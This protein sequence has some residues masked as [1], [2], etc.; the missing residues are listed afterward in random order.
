MAYITPGRRNLIL[1]SREKILLNQKTANNLCSFNNSNEYFI[2]NLSYDSLNTNKQLDKYS[3]FIDFCANTIR[4][5]GLSTNKVCEAYPIDGLTPEEEKYFNENV[6]KYVENFQEKLGK[7]KDK[8]GFQYA[9]DDL[10]YQINENIID[11]TMKDKKYNIQSEATIYQIL[12]ERV[13]QLKLCLEKS[14]ASKLEIPS[15]IIKTNEEEEYYHQEG[16]R[17]ENFLKETENHIRNHTLIEPDERFFH[18]LSPD[19]KKRTAIGFMTDRIQWGIK[20]FYA[21]NKEPM[22][23]ILDEL[24]E[25]I[26][27][28]NSII[29]ILMTFLPLDLFNND[30]DKF[31]LDRDKLKK[32]LESKG[33]K[34]RMNIQQYRLGLGEDL[35]T[36]NGIFLS[37]FHQLWSTYSLIFDINN[38]CG[39][40]ADYN[41]YL[42]LFCMYMFGRSNDKV[43]PLSFNLSSNTN[44]GL[45]D[46]ATESYSFRNR[47][48][49]NA[50][51]LFNEES[52]IKF[53]GLQLM[54]YQKNNKVRVLPLFVFI[55]L[56]YEESIKPDRVNPDDNG[57]SEL[58]S[59]YSLE[60]LKIFI[61]NSSFFLVENGE[62][63]PTMNIT[64]HE[65]YN[66]LYY[67]MRPYIMN[68]D[69]KLLYFTMRN[70]DDPELNAL[71]S[72][73]NMEEVF[74]LK[75]RY[76]NIPGPR[77]L[78]VINLRE[79]KTL[80][81]NGFNPLWIR[82]SPQ[83]PDKGFLICN[84]EI[85]NIEAITGG[86]LKIKSKKIQKTLK[87][88][89]NNTKK[90]SK[91]IVKRI[92][93]RSKKNKK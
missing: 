8:Q 37:D 34:E 80:I 49:L 42:N 13:K 92:L 45:F 33:K 88:K 14:K 71:I 20:N 87:N 46:P 11:E 52:S 12:K 40:F 68:D 78:S 9:T 16:E 89:V 1:D 61:C 76:P 84:Q 63:S 72:Q 65:I 90:N 85:P 15:R 55:D 28:D 56:E 2:F 41:I 26:E 27:R 23:Q 43:F 64:H 82:E 60:R 57:G 3:P 17:E 30:E 19:E 22:D 24:F 73:L 79:L 58:Y 48:P 38:P 50:D 59:L 18:K 29:K 4:T 35:D 47:K 44:Y 77:R 91:K 69:K 74:I 5:F 10:I 53:L 83:H 70:R 86:M 54:K 67:K 32:F 39:K 21:F 6:H 7:K 66:I 36:G 62:I 51:L 81:S 25:N 31:S 93:K 75:K